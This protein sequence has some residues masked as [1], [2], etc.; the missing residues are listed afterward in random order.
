MGFVLKGGLA[1][2]PQRNIEFSPGRIEPMGNDRT[3][4][5]VN[6]WRGEAFVTML[7]LDGSITFEQ[8]FGY[9]H[10]AIVTPVELE[11]LMDIKK[12]MAPDLTPFE[13]LTYICEGV[14]ITLG[15]RGG[16]RAGTECTVA[17]R[18]DAFVA[19]GMAE[20]TGVPLLDDSYV[21]AT[22]VDEAGGVQDG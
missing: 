13:Y 8:P 22:F 12:E 19:V 15:N 11:F 6:V 2:D 14:A 20:P 7:V 17:V 9:R 1:Y 18:K 4:F 3:E 21:L 5:Q 10:K 16:G